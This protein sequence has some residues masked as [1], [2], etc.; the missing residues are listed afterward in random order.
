MT[1]LIFWNVLHLKYASTMNEGSD[2]WY[3]YIGRLVPQ[4]YVLSLH[5]PLLSEILVSL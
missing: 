5:S 3:I 1:D 2:K 4:W